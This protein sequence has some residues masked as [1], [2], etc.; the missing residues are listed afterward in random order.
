MAVGGVPPKLGSDE[1]LLSF[2][3]RGPGPSDPSIASCRIK[4]RV[5]GLYFNV[6][7]VT[8]SEIKK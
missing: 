2:I 3:I 5:T 1:E 6:K 8:Y 7:L 4:V